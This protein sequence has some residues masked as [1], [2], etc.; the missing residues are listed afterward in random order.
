M[1]TIKRKKRANPILDLHASCINGIFV[2]CIACC[3]YTLTVH[4]LRGL[5][6]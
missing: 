4:S 2:L 6:G 5:A 3:G 1:L